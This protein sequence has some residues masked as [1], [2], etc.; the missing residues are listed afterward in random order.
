MPVVSDDS[1]LTDAEIDE[2]LSD[3]GSWIPEDVSR[4][5][6]PEPPKRRPGR[7]PGAK[8]K[9]KPAGSMTAPPRKPARAPRRPSA[10]PKPD[11][12]SQITQG[13]QLLGAGFTL[14]AATLKSDALAADALT[15]MHYSKA[16]GNALGPIA[17]KYPGFAKWIDT[18]DAGTPAAMA[19]TVALPF[20]LQ[21]A[22]NHGWMRPVESMGVVSRETILRTGGNEPETDGPDG[23]S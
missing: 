19:L 23:G 6:E 7:P 12:A 3:P 4:E 13:V 21:L 2:V 14:G 22:V 10:P 1:P 17:E 9:P 16:F 5:T 11:Y 8:N 18:M 20:T 15:L